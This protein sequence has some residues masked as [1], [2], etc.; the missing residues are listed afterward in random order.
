MTECS[1]EDVE[2]SL[3]EIL[4]FLIEAS[5]VNDQNAVIRRPFNP[6][7][8]QITYA[9]AYT[10]YAVLRRE[11]YAERYA[12]Y[13]MRRNYIARMI[14]GALLQ[15]SYEF[16]R[17]QL[18]RHRLA[19]LPSPTL[20]E[21]SIEPELY[22]QDPL[23]SEIIDRG[24]HPVALRFDFDDDPATVKPLSHPASHLTLGQ[25]ARCRIPV[26]APLTPTHFF[27]FLLR[28]FYSIESKSFAD[29]LP[30]RRD[31][32]RSTLDSADKGIVHLGLPCSASSK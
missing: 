9:N 30:S 24:S 4:A 1:L 6:R 27:D 25:Y 3:R 8:M 18:R 29:S 11:S 2:K 5:L 12:D 26:E 31:V 7:G 17:G 23:F 19:F 20:P 13:S 14:D 22:D 15:V 10:E 32:F 28:S 21:Y 16:G